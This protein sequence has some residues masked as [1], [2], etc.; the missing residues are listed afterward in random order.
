MANHKIN[1]NLDIFEDYIQ[2]TLRKVEENRSNP[3]KYI[4]NNV[5][6]EVIPYRFDSE[7]D[8]DNGSK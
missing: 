1:R 5:P 3:S 4:K 7:K 8:N 6:D 2:K